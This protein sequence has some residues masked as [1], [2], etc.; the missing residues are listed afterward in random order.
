MN[1]KKFYCINIHGY[2]MLL[3]L[4]FQYLLLLVVVV[5]LLLCSWCNLWYCMPN[6]TP[7]LLSLQNYPP[8]ELPKPV[9]LA[10]GAM[11]PYGPMA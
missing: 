6:L 3:L 9:P 7:L 1:I 11:H 10:K 4:V 8:P 2:T 5:L